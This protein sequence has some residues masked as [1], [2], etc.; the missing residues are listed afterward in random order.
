MVHS[1]ILDSMNNDEKEQFNKELWE[2]QNHKCY[3][4]EEEIV[5]G[6]HTTN[7][8]HIKP[9]ANNGKDH[10]NNMAI[11]H[12][13]CNK[14]KQD[15]DLDVAKRI[16]LLQKIKTKSIEKGTLT[17]AVFTLQDVLDYFNGSKYNFQ[18]KIDENDENTVCYCFDKIGDNTIKKTPLFIDK[19]SGEKTIF[20]DVPIQYLYHDNMNPRGLNSSVN[21]L[22]KEFS[23]PNPQLQVSL[24]RLDDNK[25]KLFDGQHK[26]VAQILVGATSTLVRIFIEYDYN[27]LEETNLIA[28]KQLRQI[29]FDKSIVRQ[30]HNTMYA[31]KI[32][33]YREDKGLPPDDLSFSEQNIVDH[34][35]GGKKDIRALIIDSQKDTITHDPNNKLRLYIN[36]E[37]R[38][39]S[40]PLSYSTFEKTILSTFINSKTILNTNLDYMA[41]EGT[42]PRILEEEQA[43]KICNIIAEELLIDKY[44]TERGTYRVEDDISK[45]KGKPISSDHLIACRLF[46]EEVMHAWVHYISLVINNNFTAVGYIYDNDNLLQ[47]PFSEILYEQIRLFLRNLRNLPAWNDRG[48]SSTIFGGKTNYAYWETIFRKGTTPDGMKV[49]SDGI[50]INDFIKK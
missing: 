47:Q 46:K 30:L 40:L 42:N 20:V 11:T 23:K 48:M 5:L 34:F 4:C 17:D 26:T 13:H 37:G 32:S 27:K 24:A 45:N 10:K 9:L 39:H 3:I 22:I 31:N 16:C 41:E 50:N 18:Y 8:D 1:K 49:F 28:G 44:D 25:I 14:S 2:I 35:K 38:G 19:I 36:F 7:I 33:Q 43:V 6:V 29:A 12:E 21:E 15:S